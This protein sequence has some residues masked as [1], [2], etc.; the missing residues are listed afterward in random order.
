MNTESPQ[1]A[2]PR[3]FHVRPGG[4]QR[5]TEVAAAGPDVGVHV[6]IDLT[7]VADGDLLDV[8]V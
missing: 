3:G 5:R 2:V 1:L 6:H 8:E 7:D 4:F